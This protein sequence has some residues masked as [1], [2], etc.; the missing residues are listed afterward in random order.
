ME[1]D[2][3]ARIQFGDEAGGIGHDQG[4]PI[5]AAAGL[6]QFQG[7]AET[8]LQTLVVIQPAGGLFQ[9]RFA[10]PAVQEAAQSQ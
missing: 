10:K 2:Q 4:A 7:G 8:F 3:F 6:A 1:G 9:G 5:F